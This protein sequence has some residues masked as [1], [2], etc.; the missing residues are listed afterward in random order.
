[1]RVSIQKWFKQQELA[2]KNPVVARLATLSMDKADV[3]SSRK[4]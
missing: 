1:M 3:F 4:R 2:Q